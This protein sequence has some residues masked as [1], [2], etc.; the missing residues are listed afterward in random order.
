MSITDYLINAMFVLIVA[1]QA[2]ERE[3]D[4]RSALLP[5]V[6]VAFVAHM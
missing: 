2:R 1:R 4:L 6:L 5:L 3:L